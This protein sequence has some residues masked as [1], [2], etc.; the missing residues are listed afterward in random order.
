MELIHTFL[1]I[2]ALYFLSGI[3]SISVNPIHPMNMCRPDFRLAVPL[4]GFILFIISLGWV[5]ASYGERTFLPV[6]EKGQ[7]PSGQPGILIKEQNILLTDLLK[8]I[9]EQ[10]GIDF[11]ISDA[12]L[13]ESISTNVEAFNWTEAVLEIVRDFNFVEVW[14]R[15]NKLSRIILLSPSNSEAS[16]YPPAG[17]TQATQDPQES[18]E[19]AYKENSLSHEQLTLLGMTAYRSPISPRLLQEPPIREFLAQ[20]DILDSED[21]KDLEKRMKA[22]RKAR[23]LL[24]EMR[25]RN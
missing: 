21:L 12:L 25:I 16:F 14:D 1:L 7:L 23:Q 15:D 19:I 11:E 13:N 17:K 20:F 4:G 24:R 18:Q 5:S 2:L 3:L 6:N 9:R 10:S 22:R 8:R